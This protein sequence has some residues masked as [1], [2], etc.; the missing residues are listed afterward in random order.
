MQGMLIVLDGPDAAGTST[1]AQLLAERLEAAGRSV[2]LT[3]EP[4]DG[5]L[6]REIREALKSGKADPMALQLLFTADRAWH[7]RHVIEPALAEGTCVVCD[8]YVPST[9][10]YAEAQGIDS[11]ELKTLNNN[12][13]QPHCTIFTLPPLQVTLQRLAMRASHEVFEREDVQRKIR[14]GYAAMAATDPSI[15]VIDT[16]AAIPVSA[17]AIWEIVKPLL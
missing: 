6:G 12:F 11:I 17:D 3:A 16:S 4:T 7:V 14:A 5:P 13:P 2:L 10:I 8:R 1:H 15:H 9:I